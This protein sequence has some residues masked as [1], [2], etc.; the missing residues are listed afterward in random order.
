MEERSLEDRSQTA[1]VTT[2]ELFVQFGKEGATLADYPRRRP[3]P[4]TF[5]PKELTN[6]GIGLTFSFKIILETLLWI[7]ECPCIS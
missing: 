4:G 6:I 1:V 5:L 3:S 7:L 2:A